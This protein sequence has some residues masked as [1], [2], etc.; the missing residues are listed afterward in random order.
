MIPG[1]EHIVECPG[2]RGLQRF[3]TVRSGNTFGMRSW[4]D[5]KQHAPM[6]PE[7]PDVVACPHC[8]R[9]YF[10]DEAQRVATI[11]QWDGS[12]DDQA[13][14]EAVPG[15][16]EPG[17]SAYYTAIASGLARDQDQERLLRIRAWWRSNDPFR[18]RADALSD[19]ENAANVDEREANL[20]SLL[21]L[22]N[23]KKDAD[24]IIT[25][26]ILRELGRWHD[27][28]SVL[29]RVRSSEH[30][31]IVQQIRALCEAQDRHVQECIRERRRQIVIRL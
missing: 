19:S 8:R 20:L 9:S 26:E 14:F 4:T 15:V 29:R 13:R 23:D 3:S 1:V 18:G 17:E 28:E 11:D 7:S 12:N 24:L 30:T 31:A 21:T 25:A 27:A 2:C 22:L 5:G 16:V 10:L 6:L